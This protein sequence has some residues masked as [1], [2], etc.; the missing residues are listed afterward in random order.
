MVVTLIEVVSRGHRHRRAAF[1]SLQSTQFRQP[2]WS[3]IAIYETMCVWTGI[4]VPQWRSGAIY[5]REVEMFRVLVA[6]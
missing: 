2:N 3:S 1:V 5:D 4:A 6:A